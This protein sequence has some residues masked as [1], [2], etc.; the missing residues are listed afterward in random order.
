[1]LDITILQEK[2]Y[3]IE[4]LYHGVDI[5]KKKWEIN[6]VDIGTLNRTTM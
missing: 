6:I 5:F 1:M 2:I 4:A 3:F